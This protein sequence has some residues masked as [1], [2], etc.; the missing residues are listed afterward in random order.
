MKPLYV[1]CLAGALA[2]PV[3]GMSVRA[4]LPV[5]NIT[6]PDGGSPLTSPTPQGDLQRAIAMI[7]DANYRGA[8]DQ[9]RQLLDSD[10]PE[11]LPG[12]QLREQAEYSY[13]VACSHIPG[14]DAAGLF[15]AFLEKY[16]AS[17]LRSQALFSLAGVLYDKQDYAA[18]L[19]LYDS[20]D[21]EV[22]NPSQA[23]KLLLD[24]GYCLLKF[25]RY[26]E[27]QRIFGSL[28]ATPAAD[29]AGFYSAYIDYVEQRYDDAARRFEALPWQSARNGSPLTM[30]PYYL[31]QIRYRLGDFPQAARM[32]RKLLDSGCPAEYLPETTRIYG[33]SLYETGKRREGVEIL[34]KYIDS[35]ESPLP[36][37][38]YILG[39]D[40]YD[41]GAY[42]GAVKLLTPVTAENNA[43]GQA[44]Y[45][46][47]GQ[48]YM[49]L[50]DYDAALL[51]LDR[52]VKQDY[53]ADVTETASYNYAVASA[54]GGKIPF[55]SSVTLFENFLDR[56]PG[57]QYAPAVADYIISGYITDKNYPAA[58]RAINRIKNPSDKILAAKQT[59]LYM[60]G[61]RQLQ[62]GDVKGAITDLT[63][64]RSLGRFSAETA[65]E[66][67]L[68]LGEA[69]YRDGNYKEAVTNYTRFLRETPSS[70]PNHSLALY[71]MA[72]ARFALKEFGEAKSGFSRFLSSI[73]KK[74]PADVVALKAD[75]H[76]RLADCLYY[77]SDLTGAEKEYSAA[78]AEAPAA[79]DY[80]L[81][82]MAVIKGLRR[83]HK[84]KIE[85]LAEMMRRFPASPL[86][87]AALLET[88]ESY[89]E[90][91]DTD[92]AIQIY[93]TLGDRFPSTPQGRQG[94]LLL[95][96]SR[97]NRGETD[98]AVAQYRKVISS[99]PTSDEARA[100]A[101]DL[102]M[103]YADRGELAE[104]TRF[105]SSIENAPRLE[106]SEI[107]A[108]QLQGVEKAVEDGRDNDALR[109]ARE[110]FDSY[111]DTPQGVEA[112]AVI[113]SVCEKQGKPAEALEAYT[114]LAN[115]SADEIAINQARMGILRLNRDLGNDEEVLKTAAQLLGSSSLGNDDRNDILLAKGLALRNTG[116]HNGAAE[117]LSLL[118]ANPVT[119]AGA[120][121]AY[122]LA[123][124]QFDDRDT[125]GAKLTVDALIDS[126]T[127]QAYWLARGFI[128]LSDI[129]RRQGNRFEAE[130]YLRSLRDN[131]PGSE[132]DIFDM[133][134]SRLNN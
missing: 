120:K 35:V 16:P 3:T 24:K 31:A 9:L 81:F 97:L 64:A 124:M 17:P 85:A 36:S 84:G 2:L 99:Y 50:G 25:A 112:L 43:M 33:E 58:L 68:W 26:D 47:I 65:S 128:L 51:A 122:Y 92:K 61:T 101:D 91:G 46:L 67:S 27:A 76:N 19:A 110:L 41:N 88:A 12:S 121:A 71:D 45:L 23:E 83:D 59:V 109:L 96:I 66:A 100:A 103:I 21:P 118:A 102:K 14:E 87:P 133:I 48:S 4:Q 60:N 20:V 75:A 95:A 115:R 49:E 129:N 116:D 55:G 90:T 54:R 22:L 6:V 30:T 123:Q 77:S 79:A 42:A 86:T 94:A 131:Y 40:S 52:A 73:G 134:D 57:S 72:Y 113:A 29:E 93:A 15:S 38:L 89:N 108:L 114:T 117:I 80:P 105:L 82:Q 1:I 78:V 125:E 34:R 18:A 5:V 63:E 13:A 53:N 28:R 130:E 39:Q 7:A 132:A 11:M 62:S 8:A 127:P 37:S 119:L 98:L 70:N 74:T 104:Y 69:Y 107:P 10:I 44:A 56:Y 126:N 106:Q 111:P 32:A